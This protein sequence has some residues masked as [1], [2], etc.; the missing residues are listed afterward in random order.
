MEELV[1]IHVGLD[2]PKGSIGVAA[3]GTGEHPH[4]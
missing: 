4:A 3:A 1:K 2:V